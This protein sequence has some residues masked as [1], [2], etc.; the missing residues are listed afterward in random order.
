[1]NQKLIIIVI[2]VVII[3]A[4][5]I[6]TTIALNNKNKNQDIDNNTQNNQEND[7]PQENQNNTNNNQSIVVYFSA[8]GNTEKIAK[9]ISETLNID[10]IEIIPE[11]KYTSDDLNYG[12][13]N[14]RSNRE[15]NDS[16]A[17]PTIRN[18]I[19]VS[20]YDT[21]Y[22]GYPIWW[23]TVPKIILTFLDTNNLDGKTIVPFCTSGSSEI[24]TSVNNLRSYNT[25]M[26]VID[27]RRFSPTA[28]KSEV[29][30]WLNEINK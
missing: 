30:T 3:L 12:N 10:T 28:T 4:I 13:N 26:Q 1:M 21:I 17:R 25:N 5:G 19:D 22:L 16:N 23:G 6:G 2:I 9:Y 7:E 29:S 27:G 15:Q 18:Q 8:T 11:N 24:S 14:S 20:S